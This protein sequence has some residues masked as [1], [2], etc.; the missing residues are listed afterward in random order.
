M[1]YGKKTLENLQF[2]FC[3][4]YYYLSLTPKVFM[5]LKG[6]S[7]CHGSKI[8]LKLHCTDGLAFHTA[9]KFPSGSTVEDGTE[10][11][12]NSATIILSPSTYPPG[13]ILNQSAKNNQN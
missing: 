8:P 6:S 1:S 7:L 2:L 5:V 11:S 9:K 4:F 13:E 10:L 3:F 12:Q